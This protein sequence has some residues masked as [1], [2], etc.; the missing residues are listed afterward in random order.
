MGHRVNTT[1]TKR[2]IGFKLQPAAVAPRFVSPVREEEEEGRPREAATV[3]REAGA[4][5]TEEVVARLGLVFPGYGALFRSAHAAIFSDTG[6]L[7]EA[8]RHYIALM[9]SIVVLSRA[10]KMFKY[11]NILQ[12]PLLTKACLTH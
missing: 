10:K 4:L 2:T 5:G 1:I 7:P 6:P 11:C 8:T 3:A 12:Q 9:V